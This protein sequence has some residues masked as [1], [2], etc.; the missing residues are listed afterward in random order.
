MRFDCETVRDFD[1]AKKKWEFFSNSTSLFDLWEFRMCYAQN[2]NYI[3]EFYN[4]N[5][6]GC[7]SIMLPLQDNG[8][9][10]EYFG[11]TYY[12][13]NRIF[14]KPGFR[15]HIADLLNSINKKVYIDDLNSNY[16]DDQL[17]GE[18]EPKYVV[19]ICG[20]DSGLEFINRYFF[21]KS[22]ARINQ[23]LRKLAGSNLKCEV[24][25]D[26]DMYHIFELNIRRFGDDSIFNDPR[27]QKAFIDMS[28]LPLEKYFMRFH[29][30]ER[31]VAATFSILYKG[32]YYFLAMGVDYKA[33]ENL[34][35]YVAYQNVELATSKGA[36]LFDALLGDNG[37]KS[38][39]HLE[40]RSLYFYKN[41]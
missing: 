5:E 41:Y 16:S 37:W 36:L 26:S 13:D 2:Y 29:I 33:I 18:G 15:T 32:T 7:P 35:M 12:E 8:D 39:F 40:P 11:G 9:Y 23:E 38:H 30:G 4:L 27:D 14:Y 17:F 21:G 22:K 25:N 20:M 31:L 6:D 10:L 24:G 28:R 19:D 3:T 1:L 34:T